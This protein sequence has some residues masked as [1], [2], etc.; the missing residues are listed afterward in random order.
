MGTPVERVSD[1]RREVT[2]MVLYVCVVLM[3]A[4]AAFPAERWDD[5]LDLVAIVWGSAVGLALAH[6]WAFDAAARLYAGGEL[7]RHDGVRAMAEV[8]AAL[9]VAVVATVP[10]LITSE[11]RASG[12]AILTLAGVVTGV[13]Y[14]S[15]RRGGMRRR[16]AVIRAVL[17][18]AVGVA[19]TA[20]KA[21]LGH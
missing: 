1:L 20:A 4:I 19:V 5:R 21:L 12:A 15:S 3:A 11:E 6:W 9:A 10:L 16:T 14:S 13:G 7:E 2:T 18:M 8:V 17:T